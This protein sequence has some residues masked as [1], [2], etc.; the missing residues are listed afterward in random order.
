MLGLMLYKAGDKAAAKEHFEKYLDLN[1]RA[2]DRAYIEKYIA[3]CKQGLS[4]K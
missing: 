2:A 1:A 4:Q 3:A